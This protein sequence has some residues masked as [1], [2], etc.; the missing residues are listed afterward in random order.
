M[1]ARR[2]HVIRLGRHGRIDTRQEK[3]LANMFPGHNTQ[4]SMH[5]T[6]RVLHT[7]IAPIRSIRA[8]GADTGSGQPCTVQAAATDWLK[9]HLSP[10]V[11]AMF[12]LEAESD[13][14][15]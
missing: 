3:D 10:G 4:D 13:E 1:S 7:I 5:T 9:Q 15:L 6:R 11:H 12:G 14:G 8:D 2:G